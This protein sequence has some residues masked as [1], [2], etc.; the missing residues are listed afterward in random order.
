[1]F[2]AVGL[3]RGLDLDGGYVDGNTVF[4]DSQGRSLYPGLGRVGAREYPSES[5]STADDEALVERSLARVEA[6]GAQVILLN[7]EGSRVVKRK[8]T[9]AAGACPPPEIS[10][11]GCDIGSSS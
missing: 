4:R 3:A 6:Q 8:S 11:S 7:L 1:M 10:Y 5:E 2:E 9:H